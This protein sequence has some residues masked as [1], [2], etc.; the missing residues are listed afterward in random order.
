MIV[1]V[2]IQIPFMCV[3]KYEY[4]HYGNFAYFYVAMRAVPSGQKLHNW[5]TAQVKNTNNTHN[6]CTLEHQLD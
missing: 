2:L 6:V 5:V 3:D 1:A 4:L